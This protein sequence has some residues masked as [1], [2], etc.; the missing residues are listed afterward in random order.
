MLRQR[1]DHVASPARFQHA[2]L[3]ADHFERGAHAELFE[4]RRNPQRRIIR[5]RLDVV[6]RIEPQ[7][8]VYGTFRGQRN[9]GQKKS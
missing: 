5:R 4:I 7:H 3:L 6:L 8:H 1:P 2:R 9:S